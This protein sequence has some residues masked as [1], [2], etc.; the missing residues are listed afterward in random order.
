MMEN[1]AKH[2]VYRPTA[3][4]PM[5]ENPAKHLVY[6]PTAMQLLSI[7]T[8]TMEVMP[9]VSCNRPATMLVPSCCYVNS[10]HMVRHRLLRTCVLWWMLLLTLLSATVAVDAPERCSRTLMYCAC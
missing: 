4:K 5:M 8:T 6:R 3:G 2:L 7:L 1:P 9:K 10:R